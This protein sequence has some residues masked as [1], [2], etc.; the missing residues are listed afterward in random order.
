MT[1]HAIWKSV[2]LGVQIGETGL[3][4]WKQVEGRNPYGMVFQFIEIYLDHS[5]SQNHGQI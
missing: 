3:T 1:L 5:S 4:K 2:V